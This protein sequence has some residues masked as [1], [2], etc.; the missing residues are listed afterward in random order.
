MAHYH[1]NLYHRGSTTYLYYLD[2][3]NFKKLTGTVLKYTPKGRR[4]SNKVEK[5]RRSLRVERRYR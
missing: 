2:T 4:E 5:Q 1:K 3:H